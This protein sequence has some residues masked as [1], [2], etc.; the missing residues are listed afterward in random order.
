[1]W[2]VFFPPFGRKNSIE[3]PA[4]SAVPGAQMA[5]LKMWG[6]LRVAACLAS[7]PRSVPYSAPFS[8]FVVNVHGD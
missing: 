3:S 6:T 4:H 1:M 5:D 7:H 8:S 2:Q